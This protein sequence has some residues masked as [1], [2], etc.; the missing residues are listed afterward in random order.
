[1]KKWNESSLSR[2]QIYAPLFEAKVKKSDIE[3]GFCQA[4][5]PEGTE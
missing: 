3:K 2:L 4:D 1:M 5:L